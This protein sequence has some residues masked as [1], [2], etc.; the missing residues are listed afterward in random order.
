[1]LVFNENRIESEDSWTE[2]RRQ[3]VLSLLTR[4]V[5]RRIPIH[6]LGIQSHFIAETNVAGPGFKRFL[7][8]IEDLGLSILVTEMDVRDY[9]LPG[10]IAVRDG[11]VAKQYYN[12]LSFILQFKSVKT[13]LTWGL[14]DRSTWLATDSPRKDGLP[15]R[16]LL[17]DAELQPKPAFAAVMR[18]FDEA[19]RR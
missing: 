9:H 3:A 4:L 5:R 1:M 17:Y 14:S 15:I 19:P 18:A 7:H 13:V 16:P 10:D 8:A 11:L 12:Y 6:G 2:R